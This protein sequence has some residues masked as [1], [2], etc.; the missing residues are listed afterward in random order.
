VRFIPD[1]GDVGD[2]TELFPEWEQVFH[3][4]VGIHDFHT[5]LS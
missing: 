4:D 3:V 2:G 5:P 1:G